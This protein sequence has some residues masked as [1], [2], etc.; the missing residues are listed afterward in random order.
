[1]GPVPMQAELT[2][3]AAVPW[4]QKPVIG[5]YWHFGELS[6]DLNTA[7]IEWWARTDPEGWRQTW[8]YGLARIQRF[9]WDE[10]FQAYVSYVPRP[11][12][13]ASAW[14]VIVLDLELTNHLH[15][16]RAQLR[17]GVVVAVG[18]YPWWEWSDAHYWQVHQM[19]PQRMEPRARGG[20]RHVPGD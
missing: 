6:A 20:T 2:E 8:P 16:A 18:H 10:N 4:G 9:E 12:L 15:T 14:Q 17:E 13:P 1:M 3:H 19:T 7:V 5:T 11:D